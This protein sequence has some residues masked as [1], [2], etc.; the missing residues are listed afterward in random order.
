[1]EPTPLGPR[2][3]LRDTIEGKT[4]RKVFLDVA[5]TADGIVTARGRVIAVHMPE[6]MA[7]S[8]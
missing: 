7:A 8:D 3:E 4:E 5:V 6:R 1:M 2:L